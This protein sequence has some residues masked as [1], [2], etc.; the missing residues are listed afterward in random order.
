MN[1]LRKGHKMV[2][3]SHPCTI[4]HIEK[5]APGKH[6]H[7]QYNVMGKSLLDGKTKNE[8][9]KHKDKPVLVEVTVKTFMGTGMDV[10]DNR[11]SFFD[12][13]AGCERELVWSHQENS[14][15]SDTFS[16]TVRCVKWLDNQDEQVI[17]VKN[18]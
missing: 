9:F 15:L 2:L 8:L 17:D 16:V 12:D 13:D 1:A 10:E 18:D 3:D 14:P 5:S 7:A 6:G 4:T 11:V